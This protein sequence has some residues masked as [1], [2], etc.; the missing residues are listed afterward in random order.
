[1]LRVMAMRKRRKGRAFYSE[2]GDNWRDKENILKHLPFLESDNVRGSL[3]LASVTL[4]VFRH[5][6]YNLNRPL[7]IHFPPRRLH[8]VWLCSSSIIRLFD[9]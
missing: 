6:Y 5:H 7:L 4:S 8:F 9:Q 3:P 1:M 2:S